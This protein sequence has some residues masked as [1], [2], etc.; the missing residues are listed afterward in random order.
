MWW[1]LAI[2]VGV[3]VVAV[4]LAFPLAICVLA[5][6]WATIVTVDRFTAW[7]PGFSHLRRWLRRR[8]YRPGR[9][10]TRFVARD[11]RR[12]VLVI[13]ASQID[14]GIIT[15]RV[16]TWNVLYAVKGLASVAPFGDVQT[17][18]LRALWAWAG[19]V[20]RAGAGAG[21]TNDR[22]APVAAVVFRPS[23]R[24]LHGTP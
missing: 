10:V 6:L 3:V 12:D 22:T 23:G 4:V 11:I 16:R 19:A 1:E 15:V 7:C 8:W 9:V 17:V 21:D 13:D 5:A 2:I 20:G 24:A 18:E 14:A